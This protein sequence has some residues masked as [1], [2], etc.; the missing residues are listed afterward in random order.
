MR[1]KRIMIV[2]DDDDIILALRVILETEGYLVA[3]S[4]TGRFLLK[5]RYEPPNLFILD[6]RVPDIDGLEVCRLLRTREEF[7]KTPVIII[8][9]SPRFG[10]QAIAAGANDF[11]EKPFE[12]HH[13]LKLVGKYA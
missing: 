9:A 8:S 5:G 13:L 11:L 10:S 4:K 1:K 7:E 12:L 3:S 2:E 6:K